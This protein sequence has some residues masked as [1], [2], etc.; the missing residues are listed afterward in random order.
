[1]IS[2]KKKVAKGRG[3]QMRLKTV[4][5]TVLIFLLWTTSLQIGPANAAS[6][7][8]SHAPILIIGNAQFT[9]SN[10]V[11]GGSGTLADP[12]VIG[13][14]DIN[15]S[16]NGIGIYNT[17]AYFSIRNVFVHSGVRGIFVTNSTHATI[18]DSMISNNTNGIV[19]QQ[20][21]GAI[22]SGNTVM[23]NLN[24][25]SLVSS[26]GASVSG[27][28]VMNNL[29][30][31]SI[32][33]SSGVSVS[34]SSNN[35]SSNFAISSSNCA[36]PFH[37]QGGSGITILSSVSST[38][39]AN[40]VAL[41]LTGLH[42]SDAP[43]LS[44]Q[45]STDTVVSGNTLSTNRGYALDLGYSPNSVI[46]SNTLERSLYGMYDVGSGNSTI[47]SNNI[48][49]NLRNGIF[50]WSGN[51]TIS[52]NSISLNG[53]AF[54]GGEWAGVYA[55]SA[56]GGVV[57]GN[58]FTAN[59]IIVP[60]NYSSLVISPS[61]LVNGKPLY[62][63]ANRAGLTV[64]GVPV[65]ELILV[66]CTNVH[67]S[68]L[69][70][71]NTDIGIQLLSV[72]GALI[73]GNTIN[74]NNISGISFGDENLAPTSFNITIVNNILSNN[75][76]INYPRFGI[77]SSSPYDRTF[78]VAYHNNFVYD[79]SRGRG[80]YDNG[81]PSGGNYWSDYNGVDNCSGL[82]QNI[83]PNP[84]GIGDTPF[85]ADRYPLIKPLL[86]APDTSPPTWPIAGSLTVS[87]VNQT[88]ITLNWRVATDDLGVVG[89]KIYQDNALLTTV[90]AYIYTWTISGLT[91]GT[92]DTFRVEAVDYA[93]NQ[94]V[95][96][97]SVTLATPGPQ[98]WIQYVYPL[99]VIVGSS[100]GI[101]VLAW[102]T[103]RRK[104]VLPKVLT[105]CVIFG[106]G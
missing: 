58:N 93:G 81:Y 25:T 76:W 84:D 83:C 64:N 77:D 31:I 16:S 55:F 72:N 8:Q 79:A 80:S 102:F 69:Q 45:F 42:C 13:G 73:D 56:N 27:N 28:A 101:L 14:W 22:V 91:P 75:G 85:G 50:L 5:V 29:N 44:V 43:A 4:P 71:T 87:N 90:S 97:P 37:Y 59:G 53:W 103:R 10:G 38:V 95:G 46:T 92:T 52:N 105:T 65:G 78:V 68:G 32:A 49:R 40:N 35:V 99:A 36:D 61:N 9:A 106:S 86:S 11:T 15:A 6:S 100:V 3:R 98:P 82:S 39:R 1:M 20:S 19:V 62:Y 30:G 63:Y 26:S 41:E 66:N 48:T 70:I 23:N 67:L 33:S 54:G 12:Y 96:G 17:T 94:S 89:Y 74:S 2:Y 24:G 88:T 34:V 18:R 51:T 104:R 60:D 7:Y 47:S 57:T 21:R